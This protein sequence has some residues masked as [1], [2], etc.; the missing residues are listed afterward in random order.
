M[1]FTSG[2]DFTERLARG[3]GIKMTNNFFFFYLKKW[4]VE[5]T[6]GPTIQATKEKALEAIYLVQ[7]NVNISDHDKVECCEVIKVMVGLEYDLDQ[8]INH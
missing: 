6:P 4:N 5:F 7:T 1:D 8:L 2:Q 3:N